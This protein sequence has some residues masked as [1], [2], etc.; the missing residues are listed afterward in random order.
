MADGTWIGCTNIIVEPPGEC[1]SDWQFYLDLAVKMGYEMTSGVEYGACMAEHS[2]N[3]SGISLDEL[4]AAP[5]GIFCCQNRP[6][7]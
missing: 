5:R 7:T 4:R 6:C 3:H 1:K 2:F